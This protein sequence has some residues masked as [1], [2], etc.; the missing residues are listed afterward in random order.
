MRKLF[1]YFNT[2]KKELI[3]TPIIVL[4]EVF[5]EI[6]IPVFMSKLIDDGVKNND[7][8]LIY[9]YGALMVISAI[10]A[11]IF[12][13]LVT[14]LAAKVSTEF[15]H[16]LR[17]AQF[18]KIQEYSFENIDNFKTSSLITR[19]TLDVN[20]IQQSTNMIIRIA[21]RSPALI[22]FS[23]ISILLFAGKLALTFVITIPILIVGFY[24]IMKTA[25][26]HFVKMFTKID[27]L[28]QTIQEDLMGIRTVKSYVREDYEANRFHNAT[29]D[30][31][32]VAIRAEKIIIFNSP[33]MQ[34]A[35]GLSFVLI[36]WFA[37]KMMVG[38]NLTEGQFANSITYINQILFSL[39]MISQVFL[40]I[41]ISR[42]SVNRI[43][44]V[45]DERPY[46]TES[47]EPVNEVRDGSFRFENVNFSY[48]QSNDKYVLKNINLDVPSGS[49]VGIFGS[50]G[51]GKTTLVQLLSRLYDTTSGSVY[52]SGINVKDYG[53]ETLRKEV[54]LVLQ[55]NV[56]FSGTIRDNIKWGKKDATDEEIIRALKQA[57]AYDFVFKMKDNLDTW[58]EQGGVNVSGG[59][60]QRLTIAR[61]L[62]ANPKILIL[63]DSTS[64]V[65]TKTDA[66]I[67]ESL[68][69]ETPDMT[70]VVIS[71]RLSSIESANIIIIMDENGI[72]AIGTHQ[73]LYEKNLMYKTIYDTQSKSKEVEQ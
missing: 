18:E 36:G 11:L 32:D 55:K 6:L 73:E 2:V 50:T 13:I 20:M 52:V 16:N 51:T 12:G 8:K 17:Q 68:K 45:L 39:M 67:R 48:N 49:F 37:S 22:I 38:G 43:N 7:M 66:K 23:I 35:I 59:Q 46:L 14:K 41:V 31:R 21:F 58:I 5:F 3:L 56:L 25:H 54:I 63:D 10:I 29:K 60:R 30:V 61:A 70:K 53:L 42:A 15:G 62:I 27:N 26:K 71:Q 64:A 34:F 65:D 4:I 33:L 28:N 1:K 24:L 57:Q 19:M 72:S 40:M 44:E 69:N 9:T 47:Q